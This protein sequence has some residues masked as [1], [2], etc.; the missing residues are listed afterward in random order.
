LE[1]WFPMTAEELE[2]LR[3]E[4]AQLRHNAEISRRRS[5]LID[6]LCRNFRS[7]R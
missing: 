6:L 3:A 5:A 2:R 4:N 1:V 7:T